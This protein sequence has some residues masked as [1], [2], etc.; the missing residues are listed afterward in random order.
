MAKMVSKPYVTPRLDPGPEFMSLVDHVREGGSI[1]SPSE[2]ATYTSGKFSDDLRVL[3]Q[4]G[5]HP[6]SMAK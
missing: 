1:R 6:L 2:I 3:N 4:L 5:S